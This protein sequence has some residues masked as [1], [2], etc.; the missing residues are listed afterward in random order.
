MK[1]RLVSIFFMY[2]NDGLYTGRMYIKIS[3]GKQGQQKG[4]S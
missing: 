4:S 2:G 3:D 1:K